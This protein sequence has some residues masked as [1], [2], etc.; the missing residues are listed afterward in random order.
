MK[1][2]KIMN[3]SRGEIM[4][5]IEKLKQLTNVYRTALNEG[6]ASDN[7]VERLREKMKDY[8]R[9]LIITASELEEYQSFLERVADK[10]PGATEIEGIGFFTH[11]DLVLALHQY[12][13]NDPNITD[14]RSNLEILASE[15]AK[16]KIA[17]EEIRPVEVAYSQLF[18]VVQRVNDLDR[19]AQFRA[20][21]DLISALEVWLDGCKTI[22]IEIW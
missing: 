17:P 16:E 3:K 20:L 8:G 12:Q 2:K 10:V 14:K 1:L 15:K 4:N 11:T 19:Y 13:K 9:N 5:G 6:I 18:D 21:N 22:D 7:W